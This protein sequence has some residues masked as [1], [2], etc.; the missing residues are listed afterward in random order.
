MCLLEQ[1]EVRG[2][3]VNEV[4]FSPDMWQVSAHVG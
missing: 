4:V 3:D 1:E 2:W